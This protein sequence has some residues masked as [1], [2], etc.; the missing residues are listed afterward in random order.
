MGA[1]WANGRRVYSTDPP[2][3]PMYCDRRGHLC[4]KQEHIL[5]GVRLLGG[6][7]KRT[8]HWVTLFI[9]KPGDDLQC[10]ASGACIAARRLRRTC[11]RSCG[12]GAVTGTELR[13]VIVGNQSPH[14]QK[15]KT[16]ATV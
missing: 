3:A 10:V 15:S 13:S 16:P 11:Y 6:N 5:C 9:K 1:Y 2:G 8:A 7:K 14:I 12:A 4:D